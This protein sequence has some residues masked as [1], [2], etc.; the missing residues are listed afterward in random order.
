MRSPGQTSLVDDSQTLEE[1]TIAVSA[2]VIRP[3]LPMT[4]G[5]MLTFCYNDDIGAREDGT[6]V[7]VKH[8]C[9]IVGK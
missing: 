1:I 3:S 6:L 8:E 2:I 4:S 7:E 5:N 9:T